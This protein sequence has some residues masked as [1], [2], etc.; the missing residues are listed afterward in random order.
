MCALNHPCSDRKSE[1]S[2]SRT[3]FIAQRRMDFQIGNRT[4]R[5]TTTEA[6]AREFCGDPTRP[7][8][9]RSSAVAQAAH[10]SPERSKRS[11]VPTHCQT[12][13]QRKSRRLHHRR[14]AVYSTVEERRFSAASSA[15]K[16][17]GLQPQ[18]SGCEPGEESA[19]LPTPLRKTAGA[20]C[21]AHPA[22]HEI[23]RPHP[24]R[25]SAATRHGKGTTSVAQQAATNSPSTVEERRFQRRVQPLNATGLQ[26][27]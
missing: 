2:E 26:P 16:E 5:K 19:A 17:T 27:R 20:P 24:S 11:S 1:T 9:G 3:I 23:P 15:K 22:G 18:R 12:R 6:E 10:Q 25:N 14:T 7:W 13:S 8:K 21:F 4:K